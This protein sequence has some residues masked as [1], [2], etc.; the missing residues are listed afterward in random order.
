MSSHVYLCVCV[1]VDAAFFYSFGV[2]VPNE[3][4]MRMEKQCL[5]QSF[6]HNWLIVER[7]CTTPRQT[8][9][10]FVTREHMKYILFSMFNAH[11]EHRPKTK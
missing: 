10:P 4:K 5:S 3:W 8:I 1:C 6:V 7:L 2:D 11:N 9:V